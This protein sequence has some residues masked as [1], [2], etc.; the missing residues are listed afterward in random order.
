[1]W[2]TFIYVVRV[3]TSGEASVTEGLIFKSRKKYD[4]SKAEYRESASPSDNFE[5]ESSKKGYISFLERIYDDLMDLH[6]K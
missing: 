4:I 6:E 3:Q 5:S 1:M 2:E